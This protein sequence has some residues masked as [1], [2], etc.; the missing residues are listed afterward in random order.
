MVF[1][2]SLAQLLGNIMARPVLSFIGE[3]NII[4]IGVIVECTRLMTWAFVK[5]VVTVIILG[6]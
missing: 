1:V 2:G 4:Y 5:Y 6:Q 3:L